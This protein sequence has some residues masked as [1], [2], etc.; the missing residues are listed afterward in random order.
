[1]S[2]TPS[3]HPE[4]RPAGPGRYAHR[5]RCACCVLAAAGTGVA[6]LEWSPLLAALAVLLAWGSAVAVLLA[7]SAAWGAAR[8]D[9]RAAGRSL[10]ARALLPGSG[11]VAALAGAGLS[12]ALTLLVLI[13]VALTCPLLVSRLRPRAGATPAPAAL[14]GPVPGPVPEVRP[15]PLDAAL[16]SLSDVELCHLWRRTFWQLRAQ[17]TPDGLVELVAL[18]QACLDELTRRNPAAVHAWLGSG[19][20]ASG[21]PERF[22]AGRPPRGEPGAAA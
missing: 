1:M 11:A 19:A 10:V 8:P 2:S 21:G 17:D 15:G 5:W 14:A 16:G 4:R 12:P 22:W 6:V 7:V 13:P 3:A 20:R 18:R 9:G